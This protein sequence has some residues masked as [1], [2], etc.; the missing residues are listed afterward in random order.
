MA[1]QTFRHA[2]MLSPSGYRLL[3]RLLVML[4]NAALEERIHARR[5]SGRSSFLHDRFPSL[6][7][8]RKRDPEWQ[9][10]SAQVARPAPVRLDRAMQGFVSRV[11]SGRDRGSC[12]FGP[13]ARTAPS[14]S[15]LRRRPGGR[16]GSGTRAAGARCAER[17]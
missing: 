10:I 8:I 12:A 13:G 17:P 6:T 15:M 14:V 1:V 7:A 11:K 2:A 5:M 16:S 9:G 4:C 3:D